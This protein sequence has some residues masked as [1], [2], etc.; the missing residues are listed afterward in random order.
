ME[1]KKQREL[2]WTT[3]AR[4]GS[5]TGEAE[6]SGKAAMCECDRDPC[7]AATG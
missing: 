3:P 2:D 4:D 6:G 7:R 1:L 5:G